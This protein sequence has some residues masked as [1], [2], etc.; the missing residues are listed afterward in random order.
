[1]LKSVPT[2]ALMENVPQLQL[3]SRHTENPPKQKQFTPVRSKR[4]TVVGQAWKQWWA[5]SVSIYESQ[6][7]TGR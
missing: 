6:Q 2:A 7:M 1:M 4:C 5:E 3:S